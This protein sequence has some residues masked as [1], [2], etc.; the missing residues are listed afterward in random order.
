MLRRGNLRTPGAISLYIVYRLASGSIAAGKDVAG[1]CVSM[2]N[3]IG[4]CFGRRRVLPKPGTQAAKSGEALR[5]AQLAYSHLLVHHD[6]C[7]P[8]DADASRD[9]GRFAAFRRGC[10]RRSG[11]VGR[12]ETAGL[13]LLLDLHHHAFATQEP[14]VEPMSDPVPAGRRRCLPGATRWCKTIAFPPC[15]SLVGF[16]RVQCISECAARGGTDCARVQDP[17][18][19]ARER[20]LRARNAHRFEQPRS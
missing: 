1:A 20:A 9:D 16:G 12:N 2:A 5:C 10:V 4:L 13:T 11:A 18:G 7:V 15:R 14:G 19:Y 8:L 17:S 6:A 3:G